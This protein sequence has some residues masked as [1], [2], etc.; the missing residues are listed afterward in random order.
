MRSTCGIS[1]APRTCAKRID[2]KR[3]GTLAN[4]TPIAGRPP[5]ATRTVPT[6]PRHIW[7]ATAPSAA[8]A[9]PVIPG[10]LGSCGESTHRASP[11]ARQRAR[12]G[13]VSSPTRAM[14]AVRRAV[15]PR[16]RADEDYP[17]LHLSPFLDPI[18]AC[19]P[20]YAGN[21]FS[22]S[23]PDSTDRRRA[24][25]SS[26][27]SLRRGPPPFFGQLRP[28][29][30]RFPDPLSNDTPRCAATR[31]R[32]LAGQRRAFDDR[33]PHSLAPLR[34]GACRPQT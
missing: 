15:L 19:K 14:A 23:S 29:A 2:R 8:I 28:P 9:P 5:P 1:G 21:D 11:V 20:G 30:R 22:V 7:G 24:V 26:G 32:T 18:R 3:W 33:Y 6:F 16:A 27:P 25:A 10:W 4:R 34:R 12:K 17:R 31:K 13:C